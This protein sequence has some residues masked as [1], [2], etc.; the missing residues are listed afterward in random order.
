[1]SL[2]TGPLSPLTAELSE[3]LRAHLR[4]MLVRL[5]ELRALAA[6]PN[7]WTPAVDVYETEDSVQVAVE[8]PGVGADQLRI[9]VLDGTLKIE[10][11]KERQNPTG[12]LSEGMAG[13]PS[14]EAERPLR[15]I[16]LERGYGNFAFTLSIRWPIEADQVTAQMRDGVLHVNL[17]KAR[18]CGK[19]ISIP[20]TE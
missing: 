20:I 17:P 5:D 7:T 16:C 13:N 2:V 6:S 8:V 19:E 1:M 3:Q 15:F 12:R 18:N 11:R 4:R 14:S 10:G 9:K